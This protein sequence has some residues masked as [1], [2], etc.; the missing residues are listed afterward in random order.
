MGLRIKKDTQGRWR[1][2]GEYMK[3]GDRFSVSSRYFPSVKGNPPAS[4]KLTDHGDHAFEES[5]LKAS[6]ILDEI[7]KGTDREAAPADLARKIFNASTGMKWKNRQID[8]LLE[9]YKCRDYDGERPTRAYLRRNET[10][11][12]NFIAWVKKTNPKAKIL[13]ITSETAQAY[14]DTLRQENANGQKLTARSLRAIRGALSL[15][16]TSPHVL[17]TGAV[18]PFG[19]GS[20]AIRS[21]EGDETIHREPILDDKMIALVKACEASDDR[22][23]A[24]MIIAGATT[25]LRRGDVALLKWENVNLDENLPGVTWKGAIHLRTSKTGAPVDLPIVPRLH[26]ILSRRKRENPKKCSLVFP[27][28]A[29][30]L[31]GP[32]LNG[33]GAAPDTLTARFK[34]IF[35]AAFAPDAL[36]QLKKEKSSHLEALTPLDKKT[37]ERAK[38]LVQRTEWTENRK[39]K[40]IDFLE[41]YAN[42]KGLKIIQRETGSSTGLISLYLH[43]VEDILH[44]RFVRCGSKKTETPGLQEV[45]ATTTR[46]KVEGRRAVSIYDFH[47]LRTSFVTALKLG[48]MRDEEIVKFTGH[49]YHRRADREGSIVLEVNYNKIRATDYAARLESILPPFLTGCTPKAKPFQVPSFAPADF[50]TISTLIKGLSKQDRAKLI[51]K[52]VG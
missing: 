46:R 27:E 21:H 26:R 48:G 11:I 31:A 10:I 33:I 41:R 12:S 32:G 5:R 42:G 37:L 45:I 52:L 8:F 50:E 34:M 6:A 44:I 2:Y 29:R 23:A 25:A 1:W 17:P 16:F 47:A 14:R 20:L 40:T 15:A 38:F 22:E 3:D 35:V 13:D 36:T 4:G 7:I 19:K 24:D 30:L 18:N 43:A 9:A 28:A 39:S 51:S 49:Q